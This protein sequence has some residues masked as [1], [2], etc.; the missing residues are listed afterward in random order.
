MMT[1]QRVLTREEVRQN[2]LAARAAVWPFNVDWQCSDCHLTFRTPPA[3]EADVLV[4]TDSQGDPEAASAVCPNCGG[5]FF[6]NVHLIRERNPWWRRL[7]GA[8]KWVQ[9]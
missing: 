2:K 7:L 3:Q 6:Y 5:P 9:P 8:P 4:Y 1:A